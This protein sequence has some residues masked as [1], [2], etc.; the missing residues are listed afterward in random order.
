MLLPSMV[1]VGAVFSSSVDAMDK[2]TTSF[3][4]ASVFVELFDTMDV[5]ITGVVTSIVTEDPSVVVLR[6]VPPRFSFTS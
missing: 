4:F 1:T 3:A 5:V 6:D 2:V